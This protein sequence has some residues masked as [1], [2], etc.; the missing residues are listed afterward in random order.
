MPS[1][2]LYDQPAVPMRIRAEVSMGSK[3]DVGRV[4]HMAY[5]WMLEIRGAFRTTA[6]SYTSMRGCVVGVILLNF[7][8]MGCS[9]N[10]AA[11]REINALASVPAP[12]RKLYVDVQDAPDWQNPYIVVFADGLQVECRAV[13][14]SKRITA[15]AL[16]KTLLELP[17]SAWPYGKIVAGN[18]NSIRSQ[19]DAARIERNRVEVDKILKSMD[20]AV[21]W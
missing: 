13:G 8:T 11:T 12:D 9:P 7:V 20:I 1:Q 3:L 15:S 2:S 19:G 18:E 17:R 5:S 16:K 6:V 4:A 21:D 14:M 10:R